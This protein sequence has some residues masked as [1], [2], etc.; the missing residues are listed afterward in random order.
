M[1]VRP[2][3][4]TEIDDACERSSFLGGRFPGA[5]LEGK[6]LEVAAGI[7]PG[8]GDTHWSAVV[9]CNGGVFLRPTLRATFEARTPG[10]CGGPLSSEAF[11]LLVTLLT[12]GGM[13]PV[14]MTPVGMMT[15]KAIDPVASDDT[16]HLEALRSYALLHPEWESVRRLLG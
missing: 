13:R 4:M 11:G 2:K 16:V 1:C 15:T 8:L 6:V 9:L 3:V 5:S 14:G 12:L 7:S 10:G